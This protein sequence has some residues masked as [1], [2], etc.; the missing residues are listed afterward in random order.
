MLTLF[1]ALLNE[2]IRNRICLKFLFIASALIFPEMLN[3]GIC[4]V[5]SRPTDYR[6]EFQFSAGYSPQSSTLV[7]TAMD[8][9]FVLA[10]F[11]YS[12]ACWNPKGVSL[13]Y[14]ASVMPAAILLQ[15]SQYLYAEL[16]SGVYARRFSPSH[17]VYGAGVTPIGFT[18]DLLRA[19]RLHPFLQFDA[20]VIASTEP[21]PENVP[22]ATGLNF[23]FDF[24]GGAQW[25][26]NQGHAVRLGYKFLHI[27]NANT[28]ATNPGVDNNVFYAGFSFLK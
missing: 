10:G 21:I 3:A 5:S 17:A 16:S 9:R 18:A 8:R 4:T 13:S 6:H 28:T 27:S 24:G 14:T 19:Q 7:G 20:G 22:N 23:L 1:F 26:L 12:Y 15:P 25:R 11:S 2:T